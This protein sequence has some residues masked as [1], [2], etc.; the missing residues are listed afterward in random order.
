MSSSK[1]QPTPDLP[2]NGLSSQLIHRHPLT[3]T[4]PTSST[5]NPTTA[6]AAD[7]QQLYKNWFRLLDHDR[8]GAVNDTDLIH[9]L[10]SSG[11]S[12]S[13]PEVKK[14]AAE[15]VACRKDGRSQ[16][17][18]LVKLFASYDLTFE[19]LQKS[20]PLWRENQ[21]VKRP[22]D[23]IPNPSRRNYLMARLF[24]FYAL[25]LV[26]VTT[27]H[28]IPRFTLYEKSVFA[29]TRNV[30]GSLFTV[31][32]F[33]QYLIFWLWASGSLTSIDWSE[34]G[35]VFAF[36]LIGFGTQAARESHG[37]SLD[38][39]R[40]RYMVTCQLQLLAHTEVLTLV[41]AVGGENTESGLGLVLS[42]L[43]VVDLGVQG[44]H[45]LGSPRDFAGALSRAS[46]SPARP[47]ATS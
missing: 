21:I 30:M 41:S 6:D 31:V 32:M 14:V 1:V 13:V 12:P 25:F 26:F 39:F 29:I 34:L 11:V 17:P 4:T 40:Q 44:V 22:D 43:D 27:K 23:F 19:G 7:D 16:Y 3:P 5:S 36:C 35:C 15:L 18:E 2:D 33:N 46:P 20:L 28:F 10:Y 9:A 8:N 42:M 24:T 38:A 37:F 47:R 45:I